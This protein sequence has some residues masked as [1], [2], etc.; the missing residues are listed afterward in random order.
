MTVDRNRTWGDG[1]I[2]LGKTFLYCNILSELQSLQPLGYTSSSSFDDP[3]TIRVIYIVMSPLFALSTCKW[4]KLDQKPKKLSLLM[5]PWNSFTATFI[6]LWPSWKAATLPMLRQETWPILLRCDVFSF[7][8]RRCPCQIGAARDE[9]WHGRLQKLGLDRGTIPTL[10]KDLNVFQLFLGTCR[11]FQD[12][13]QFLERH[14]VG[15]LSSATS[16][17]WFHFCPF[18]VWVCIF[19]ITRVNPKYSQT[20]DLWIA[21]KVSSDKAV[22]F[23]G[24]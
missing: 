7:L 24:S 23:W 20:A 3:F 15:A 2:S 1:G 22:D 13:P 14:R 10:L 21:W 9:S 6:E 4:Q 5:A 16:R 17:M 19:P 18:V 12:F 11:S 8:W